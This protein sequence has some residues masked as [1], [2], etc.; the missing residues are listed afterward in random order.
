LGIPVVIG[1]QLIALSLAFA[2]A[3]G[4]VSNRPAI[5]VGAVGTL[6]ALVIYLSRVIAASDQP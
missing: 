5:V 1:P 2:A 6:V 3:S 4:A